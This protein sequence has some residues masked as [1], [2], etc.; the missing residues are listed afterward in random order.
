MIRTTIAAAAIVLAGNAL[1]TERFAYSNADFASPEAVEALHQRIEKSARS[2]CVREY[3]QAK[4][5]NQ[6]QECTEAVASEIIDGI[7]DQ[8]LYAVAAGD[9]HN[10]G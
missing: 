9:G 4:Y 10:A 8:R 6:L 7:G 5:L 3:L 2:Y 1:A